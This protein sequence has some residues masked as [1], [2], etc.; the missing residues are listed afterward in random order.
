[1]RIAVIDRD[2]CKPK[3][4]S[5]ECQKVCPINRA[6][7]K[8][9]WVEDKARIDEALCVGCGLCVKKCPFKAISVVNTPEQLKETPVQV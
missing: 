4:C 5:L 8:C 2:L 6:G 9:C 7:E 3:K 1:M